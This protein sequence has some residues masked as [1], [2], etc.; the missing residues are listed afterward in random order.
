MSDTAVSASSRT[1]P[2]PRRIAALAG[3]LFAFFMLALALRFFLAGEAMAGVLWSCVVGVGVFVFLSARAYAWRYLY[4]GVAA[5][6]VFVVFPILYTFYIGFSNYGGKN[7]LTFE[8]T[9]Q[10][11]LEETYTSSEGNYGFTLHGGGDAWRIRLEA[12]DGQA[13][14]SLPLKLAEGKQQKVE[15]AAERSD[16]ALG[17]PA[18]I[19]ALLT[20]QKGL[21]ALAAHLPDGSEAR[22]SGLR[23]FAPARQLYRL[24]ADGSLTNVRDNTTL[25]ANFKTGYWVDTSTGANVPP[26]FKTNIGFANFVRVF[27]EPKFREPFARI[28]VWTIVFAALTVVFTFALGSFLAVVLNWEALRFRHVYRTLLFLPYAVPGFISIL[29][30]RGLFNQSFGEINMVLNALFGI[31]PEWMTDPFL[32]KVMLLIVN[33]WLG[34]PYIML[35]AMGLIKSVPQDLYEA[36]A[37]AGAGPI[38]NFFKITLPL[39]TKPMLPLLVSSFAF[40]FN[41]FVL[42]SFLTRGGPDFLDTQVLAGATDIVVSYTYR[43]AFVDSGQH[44]GLAAAVSTIVFMLVALLSLLQMRLMKIGQRET[45]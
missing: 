41:N 42:I 45:R 30:F 37:I 5:T 40:N 25:V 16:D 22:L 7:L 9:R 36:S 23:Q 18:T 1:N 3:G 44:F 39:I 34:Y 26:G 10:Y 11:L 13:F 32:A 24:N 21:K 8:R 28:F 27:T 17:D 2:W 35:L 43:I 33:T 12:P 38:M 29:V 31:R 19:K 14:V 6:L 4:P 15:L 20:V